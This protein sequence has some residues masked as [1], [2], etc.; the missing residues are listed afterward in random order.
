MTESGTDEKG[1]DMTRLKDLKKRWM[2]DPE[3]QEAYARA[4]LNVPSLY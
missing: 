4:G 1:D 3:F 2:E